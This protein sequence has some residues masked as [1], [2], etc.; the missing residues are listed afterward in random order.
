MLKSIYSFLKVCVFYDFFVDLLYVRF[1]KNACTRI[2]LPSHSI[3][4][5]LVEVLLLTLFKTVTLSS[6]VSEANHFL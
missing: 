5:E 1:S 4:H 3:S 2:N 6:L